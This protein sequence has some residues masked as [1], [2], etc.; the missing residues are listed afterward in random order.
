MGTQSAARASGC[1]AGGGKRLTT[2]E[3][4][5]LGPSA[6][7]PAASSRLVTASRSAHGSQLVVFSRL[8][9]SRFPLT[10]TAPKSPSPSRLP[11]PPPV[12]RKCEPCLSSGRSRDDAS[13]CRVDRHA[14]YRE[15]GDADECRWRSHPR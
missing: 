7:Q 12:G 2:T 5:L 10:G 15:G 13:R 4:N 14:Q 11:A 3:E 6:E 1:Q 8:C 9:S